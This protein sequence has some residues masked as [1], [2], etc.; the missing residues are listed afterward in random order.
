MILYLN[1]L[2]HV[3]DKVNDWSKV[4]FIKNKKNVLD[5][6]FLKI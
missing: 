6:Y 1:S 2:I 5:M 4:L 3:I